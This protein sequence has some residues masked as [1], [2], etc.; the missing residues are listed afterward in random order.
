MDEA[1]AVVLRRRLRRQSVI[2][3]GAR[4]PRTI[5]AMEAGCGAHLMGRILADQGHEVRLM[6]PSMSGPT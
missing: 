6:S 4:L 5:F 2:E 3:L 1:G